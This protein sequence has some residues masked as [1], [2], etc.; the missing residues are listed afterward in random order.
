M[1]QESSNLDTET[2]FPDISTQIGE[3]VINAWKVTRRSMQRT[4]S[5]QRNISKHTH[6]L[7]HKNV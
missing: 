5:Q 2:E 1:F 6:D 4:N 7:V 3:V